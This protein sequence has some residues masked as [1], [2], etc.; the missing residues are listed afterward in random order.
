MN[1]YLAADHA[2]F[3]LKERIKTWLVEQAFEVN[4]CGADTLI[5]GDN[6]P[7]YMHAA[8]REMVRAHADVRAIVFGGSGTGEA[9]VMNRYAGLRAVV[10][11]GQD[12]EIVRLGRA[13]NDANVLSIGAR[14]V[15]SDRLPEILN[16][17]LNT[18]FEGGRH[19]Q[20]V[21]MIDRN[22]L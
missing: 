8:A 16:I 10:Y 6:Y 22:N 2:G 9:I 19:E 13:H 12:P 15:D 7:V 1:I 4:D 3:E 5:D 21:L 11:N 17:F 14:F 18:E 20:R